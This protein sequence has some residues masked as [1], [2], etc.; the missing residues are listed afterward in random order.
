MRGIIDIPKIDSTFYKNKRFSIIH[1][2]KE[3]LVGELHYELN[4]PIT[5]RIFP[6]KVDDQGRVWKTEQVIFDKVPDHGKVAWSV[7][8]NK[9]ETLKT[10]RV[11]VNGYEL[12]KEDY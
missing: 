12:C 8:M 11:E 3:P 5:Q 6:K 1:T 2:F 7:K 9:V 10:A 4:L